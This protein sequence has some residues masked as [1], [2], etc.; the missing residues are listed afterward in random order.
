MPGNTKDLNESQQYVNTSSNNGYAKEP[1]QKTK[2]GRQKR[3]YVDDADYTTG[4]E[5]CDE[6]EGDWD[7]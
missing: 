6:L 2:G 3:D 1:A 7:R 4:G 5:S